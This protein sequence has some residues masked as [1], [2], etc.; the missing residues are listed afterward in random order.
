MKESTQREILLLYH[1]NKGHIGI[2]R[3]YLI[4]LFLRNII[5][6]TCTKMF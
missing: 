5:G 6:T 3:T 1:E 4:D 2:E